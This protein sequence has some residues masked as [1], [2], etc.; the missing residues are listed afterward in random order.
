MDVVVR[1][2]ATLQRSKLMSMV[3]QKKTTNE[4]VLFLKCMIESLFEERMFMNSFMNL[5]IHSSEKH[6]QNIWRRNSKTILDILETNF[7]S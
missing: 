1:V 2:E 3:Y 6:Q 4:S 5:H 7:Q